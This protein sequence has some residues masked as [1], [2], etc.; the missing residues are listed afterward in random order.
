MSEKLIMKKRLKGKTNWQKVKSLTDKQVI[1]VA[2]SDPDAMPLT[3]DQLKQLAL[4]E[5]P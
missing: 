2:K 4:Q 5:L 3:R 1:A